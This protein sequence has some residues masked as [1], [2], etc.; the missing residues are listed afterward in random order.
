MREIINMR[1]VCAVYS[2]HVV[3]CC[4]PPTFNFCTGRSQFADCGIFLHTTIP[5]VDPGFYQRG[6]CSG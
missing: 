5:G 3:Q 2:T 1:V 6:G 4:Q